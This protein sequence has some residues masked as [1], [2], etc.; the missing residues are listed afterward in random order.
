[1]TERTERF[2]FRNMTI[3]TTINTDT[4][5][6]TEHA[7]PSATELL[8]ADHEAVSG[9]QPAQIGYRIHPNH[10]TLVAEFR[11][12][13]QHSLELRMLLCDECGER[14]DDPRKM[15]VHLRSKH[16]THQ[17]VDA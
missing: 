16:L 6:Q 15:A 8:P 10:D 9:E 1:M 11:K 7:I 14:I 13:H 3:Q 5:G 2:N 4:E 17:S 12:P